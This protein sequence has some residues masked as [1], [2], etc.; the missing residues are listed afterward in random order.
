MQGSNCLILPEFTE[1]LDEASVEIPADTKFLIRGFNRPSKYSKEHMYD[2]VKCH[3][4]RK[5][6]N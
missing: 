1:S 5:S 3:L 4:F 6:N 2:Q